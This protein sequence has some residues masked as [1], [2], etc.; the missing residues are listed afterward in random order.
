MLFTKKAAMAIVALLAFG[1]SCGGSQK[2]KDNNILSAAGSSQIPLYDGPGF[3]DTCIGCLAWWAQQENPNR[4]DDPVYDWNA[5]QR[6]CREKNQ[7]GFFEYVNAW[8]PVLFIAK[9]AQGPTNRWAEW[10]K[11]GKKVACFYVDSYFSGREVCYESP[12]TT[13]LPEGIAGQVSSFKLVNLNE[14]GVSLKDGPLQ[15]L[16]GDG[17]NLIK[18]HLDSITEVSF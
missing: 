13:R 9:V 10:R 4:N 15:V 3:T 18:D 16:Q 14:I 17:Y 11:A 1:N 8:S 12:I 5:L 6:K 7:C 2:S